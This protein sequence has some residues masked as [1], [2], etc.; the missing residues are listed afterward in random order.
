[1]DE[2]S[3]DNDPRQAF[4]R[5]VIQNDGSSNNSD[6]YSSSSIQDKPSDNSPSAD[7][8]RPKLTADM[9]EHENIAN[10]V[11]ASGS[12]MEPESICKLAQE[13]EQ[14]SRSCEPKQFRDFRSLVENLEALSDWRL[15]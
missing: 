14:S 15:Q 2:C 13:T 5:N 10:A 1:M 3:T 9:T 4:T 6:D 11:A 7:N 12:E 8:E